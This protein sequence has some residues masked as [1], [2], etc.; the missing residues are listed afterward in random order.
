ML[1]MESLFAKHNLIAW[2]A[3]AM[4]LSE[5]VVLFHD[6]PPQGAGNAEI[7]DIGLGYFR[8]ILPLPHARRRLHLDDA[9]RVILLA[10]RFQ[11]AHCVALDEGSRLDAVSKGW[12]I[13]PRTRLLGYD[14][15]V[16]EGA[17]SRILHP[18]AR[19]VISDDDEEPDDASL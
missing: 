1:A 14:G 2:S 19:T 5:R 6:N 17:Q 10:Q 9:G 4:A 12:R 3:G 11:D 15:Q 18:I 16:H 7:L 13:F 8:G